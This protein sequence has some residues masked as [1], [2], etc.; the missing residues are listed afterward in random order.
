[1]DRLKQSFFIIFLFFLLIVVAS[2]PLILT[3]YDNNRLMNHMNITVLPADM[4][5]NE[6]VVSEDF[7]TLRRLDTIKKSNSVIIRNNETGINMVSI[8]EQ[9]SLVQTMENQLSILHR[10]QVLPQLAF[11]KDYQ[12]VIDKKTY[13]DAQNPSDAVSIWDIGVEYSDFY[14]NVFM[15]TD[16][17]ILYYIYI[18]SK[19]GNLDCNFSNDNR[20]GFKK[21][22][23][24]DTEDKNELEKKFGVKGYYSSD[25]IH[26]YIVYLNKKIQDKTTYEFYT[27]SDFVDSFEYSWIPLFSFESKSIISP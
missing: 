18:Y 14:V 15:D 25:S 19:N 22:L 2:S 23:Q 3:E 20:S 12:V 9:N 21:Y 10:M 7:N 17:F 8:E 26:L 13:M 11:S 1:M 27:S 16:T 6:Q 4:I 24:I 5:E